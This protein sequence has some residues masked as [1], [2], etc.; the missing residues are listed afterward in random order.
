MRRGGPEMAKKIRAK[1]DERFKAADKNN[2]GK[3]SK[4]EASDRLKP[5][6]E[7]IDA[8]KDGQLT[9]EELKKAFRAHRKGKGHNH[10]SKGKDCKGKAAPP[11][12]P[13]S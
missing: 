8:D 1:M 12:P 11:K 4:D 5:H 3:L 2:D 7:K 9:R 10:N 6:F 13:K